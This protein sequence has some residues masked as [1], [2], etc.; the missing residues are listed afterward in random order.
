MRGTPRWPCGNFF[1]IVTPGGY[2]VTYVK[3]YTFLPRSIP[4]IIHRGNAVWIRWVQG[5]DDV[6]RGVVKWFNEKKGFGF[7]TP[8]DGGEDLFVHHSKIVG[9]GFKSLQ[10]GQAVEFTAAP[11]RKGLEATDVKPC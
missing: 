11:G 2:D 1:D 7:I 5:E 9:D 10:D 8:D 3:V 4:L 6:A